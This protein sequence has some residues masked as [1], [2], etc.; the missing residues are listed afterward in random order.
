MPESGE[1]SAGWWPVD[2]ASLASS[3]K[4]VKASTAA[5]HL[6]QT[7]TAAARLLPSRPAPAPPPLRTPPP[8]PPPVHSNPFEDEAER[9]PRNAAEPPPRRAERLA[10]VRRRS[11]RE[12]LSLARAVAAA[13]A[14]RQDVRAAYR[15]HAWRFKGLR[16]AVVESLQGKEWGDSSDEDE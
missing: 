11:V 6:L 15:A 7:H 9:L 8:P 12:E 10:P 5:A 16:E 4:E 13:A 3:A 2:A 14:A 1:A